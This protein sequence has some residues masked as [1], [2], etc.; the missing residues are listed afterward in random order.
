MAEA[1]TFL[2]R[3]QSRT[4]GE[5]ARSDGAE[6]SRRQAVRSRQRQLAQGI[7]S[8]VDA[9][10]RR[11]S[12]G[13]P[14]R[15]QLQ[16]RSARLAAGPRASRR[17]PEPGRAPGIPSENC[18]C[19]C[20]RLASRRRERQRSRRPA[21]VGAARMPSGGGQG[22]RNRFEAGTAKVAPTGHRIGASAGRRGQ[23][24]NVS[25]TQQLDQGRRSAVDRNRDQQRAQ[26]QSMQAVLESTLSEERHG[27][28][29]CFVRGS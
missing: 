22:A 20:R 11:R 28:C 15:M 13:S 26:H 8:W 1:T 23:G 12:I 6:A 19:R 16:A 2:A 27:R 25:D 17:W 18:R 4:E 9:R 10:A 14:S 3:E 21:R 7:R 24:V 5:D 29:C